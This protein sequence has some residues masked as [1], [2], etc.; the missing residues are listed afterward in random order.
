MNYIIFLDDTKI[1]VSALEKADAPMGV[2][3]GNISFLQ[4]S[5]DY[6]F[7]S[8]YCKRNSI[9]VDEDPECKFISTQTIPTLKVYNKNGIEIKGI[10]C[11]ITGIDSEEF[12]INIIGIPYPFYEEEFPNHVK[13]YNEM[14]GQ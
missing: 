10:G 7:F 12:E 2:V 6:L 14:F 1:G 11:Y 3:F 8:N 5:F 9:T 4:D 13:E